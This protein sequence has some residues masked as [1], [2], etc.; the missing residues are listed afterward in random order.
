MRS[1][2]FWICALM[3]TAACAVD[4]V[5]TSQTVTYNVILNPVSGSGVSG[6]AR[7]VLHGSRPSLVEVE[8]SGLRAD[9]E[10]AGHVHRGACAPDTAGPVALTLPPVRAG[11]NGQGRASLTLAEDSI[12]N[13]GYYI[14]YHGAATPVTCGDIPGIT[15][16]PGGSIPD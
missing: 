12:L 16:P 11:A 3:F 15:R 5:S 7:L 8:L 10:Y 2:R 4:P 9:V 13:A 14:D 6:L 1:P